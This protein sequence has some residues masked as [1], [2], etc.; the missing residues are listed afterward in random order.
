MMLSIMALHLMSSE[1]I[2]DSRISN[3]LT[4]ALHMYVA[5]CHHKISHSMTGHTVLVFRSVLDLKLPLTAPFKIPDKPQ[6][7]SAKLAHDLHYRKPLF[8][9]RLVVL[10]S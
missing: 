6:I 7:L 8:A 5:A 2:T 4:H 9:S 10:F 3:I 1:S